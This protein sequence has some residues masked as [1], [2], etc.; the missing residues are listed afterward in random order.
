M[1]R[2][3]KKTNLWLLVGL[4]TIIL[5]PA[6]IGAGCKKKSP[7]PPPIQNTHP[8]STQ[9]EKVVTDV[10]ESAK[11][12]AELGIPPQKNLINIIRA[13]SYRGY[14]GPAFTSWYGRTAPDFTLTDITGKQHKLSDYRGRNVLLV[15]WATWCQPCH[16]MDTHLIELRKDIGQDDLAILGISYVSQ[17]PPNTAEMIKR[18]TASSEINYPV[19]AADDRNIAAPYNTVTSLPSCIFIRPQ[20]TIKLA[21]S[22]L[23]SLEEFKAILQADWPKMPATGR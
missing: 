17:Y 1:H 4:S 21:T 2:R 22:G 14:W 9:P 23:I 15:F 8:N 20:G 16:I 7:P 13:A 5:A 12:D 18:F 10:N 19:F 11:P 6:I 3:N